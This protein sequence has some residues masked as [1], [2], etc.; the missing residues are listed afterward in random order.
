MQSPKIQ[1]IKT[2]KPIAICEI[3]AIGVADIDSYRLLKKNTDV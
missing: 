1:T 3:Y 2:I